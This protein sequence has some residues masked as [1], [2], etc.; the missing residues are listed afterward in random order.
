MVVLKAPSWCL[1]VRH[2]KEVDYY[3]D[4]TEKCEALQFFFCDLVAVILIMVLDSGYLAESLIEGDLELE[5]AHG[6]IALIGI[7]VVRDARSA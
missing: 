6:A 5:L 4:G 3:E 7:V 2:D 1:H